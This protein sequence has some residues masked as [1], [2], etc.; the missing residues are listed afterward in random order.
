MPEI[1]PNPHPLFVH[2]PIAL[3]T[4]SAMFHIAAITLRGK[5]CSSHCSVIAHT[6][7]WLGALA[8]LP[9]VF[10]GWQA[11]NSVNHD[12]A[13]H[14][15]MLLHRAW[16]LSTLVALTGLASWDAWR[17]KVDVLPK[18]WFVGAMI[19]V[20]GMVAT[21]AWHGA[22]LVYRHGLGVLSLP[23]EE[24][25][26]MQEPDPMHMEDSTPIH[27]GEHPHDHSHHN[28]TH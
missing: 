14:A 27:S 17:N 22:D 12:E 2:F 24:P 11:F 15:A 6:T 28:H 4:V 18:W 26:S 3:I 5:A 20:W 16:A 19:G 21:T 8:M 13:G 25:G 1:I 23:A 7:L 10:F 9:T